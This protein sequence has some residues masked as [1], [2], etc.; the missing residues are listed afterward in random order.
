MK[1]SVRIRGTEALP[2]LRPFRRD[3]AAAYDV[4]RLHLEDVGKIA[5]QRD[6]E[7]KTYWPHAVVG[8]V[9]IFVQAADDGSTD[10]EADGTRRDCTVFG[11]NGLIK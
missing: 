3:L 11:E 2:S 4:A 7:L 8:D 9:E 10:R 6:F 5:S 1:I